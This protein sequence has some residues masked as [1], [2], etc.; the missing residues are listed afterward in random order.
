MKKPALNLE[1]IRAMSVLDFAPSSRQIHFWA[2]ML[3]LA[4][5]CE[6]ICFASASSPTASSRDTPR[7]TTATAIISSYL[8]SVLWHIVRKP[9]RI[10]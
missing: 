10:G 9:A 2:A 7:K 8:E 3:A 4:R 6:E 5:D 1:L